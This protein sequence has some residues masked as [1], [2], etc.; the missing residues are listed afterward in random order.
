MDHLPIL[1]ILLGYDDSLH[2]LSAWS[3]DKPQQE[4]AYHPFVYFPPSPPI[5]SR[6]CGAVVEL[7]RATDSFVQQSEGSSSKFS[8]CG[9]GGSGP[10]FCPHAIHHRPQM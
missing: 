7:G 10:D 1:L 3:S 9:G 6:A 4:K 5:S 8:W 2:F